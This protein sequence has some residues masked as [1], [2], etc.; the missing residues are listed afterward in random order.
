MKK[1]VFI[2]FVALQATNTV[3]A[4]SLYKTVRDS[5]TKIINDPTSSHEKIDICQFQITALNYMVAQ[6]SKRGLNNKM[7]FTK[8]DYFS[9]GIY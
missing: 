5:A 8:E 3:N 7:V 4:Q 6:V 1:L 9:L 2:A